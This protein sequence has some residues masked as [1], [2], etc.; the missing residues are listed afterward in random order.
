MRY[1]PA[2]A[3]P[4]YAFLPGSGAHPTRDP[5]GHS[6]GRD[7]E[8]PRYFEV[9]RWR[10]NEDYLY[11]ID[12]YNHGYLWEAHEAWEGIW[13]KAKGDKPQASFL[14]GLIQCTAACLKIPME[15]PRGLDSLSRLGC[16]KISAVALSEGDPYM[17][18]EVL[19]FAEELRAFAESSPTD[20]EGR[21]RLEVE[22]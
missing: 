21:P 2:R 15:Q 17:G 14:Q 1:L 20:I 13:H 12:L 3:F 5:R 19:E 8:E 16:A 11:G 18:L 6:F 4:A 9:A 22:L 10:E 7:E